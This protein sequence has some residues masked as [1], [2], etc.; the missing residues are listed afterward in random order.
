MLPSTATTPQREY[1]AEA[2]SR[3]N[4]LPKTETTTIP[5]TESGYNSAASD[6]GIEEPKDDHFSK[7]SQDI[8][9]IEDRRDDDGGVETKMLREENERLREEISCRVCYTKESNIVFLPCRHLVTC[10][11]CADGVQK[12]PVCRAEIQHMVKIF[13][14]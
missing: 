10:P 5:Q 9:D 7:G 2:G 3:I 11:D 8:D 13:K 12:C 1:L 4:S 14:S 6:E